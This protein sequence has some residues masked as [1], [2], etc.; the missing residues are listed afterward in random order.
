MNEYE[1]ESDVHRNKY[2]DDW[3]NWI[4]DYHEI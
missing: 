4:F 1:W 2:L 3:R